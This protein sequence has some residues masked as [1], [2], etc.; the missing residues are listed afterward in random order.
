VSALAWSPDA[1][2]FAIGFSD[3][4]ITIWN[5][6][7][8]SAEY[9]Y[10]MHT[11]SLETIVWSPDGKLIAS[12]GLS[13]GLEETLLIINAVD[14]SVVSRYIGTSSN[15]SSFLSWSPDSTRIVT[16]YD[17][18]NGHS[19]PIL[20]VW[21][22]KTS[23]TLLTFGNA[24][25]QQVAWSPDGKTIA[26][27][28]NYNTLSLF[29]ASNGQPIRSFDTEGSSV[30]STS[31]LWSI[32]LAWSPDSQ[33][34]ALDTGAPLDIQVRNVKNNH[35]RSFPSTLNSPRV[36]MWLPDRPELS[37]TDAEGEQITFDVAGL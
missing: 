17:T 22:V 34:L 8:G 21:D 9:R 28:T 37:L 3:G 16:L 4:S 11:G 31:S 26:T 23:K 6:N 27:Y 24:N 19:Q 13:A 33:Y 10:H 15:G 30:P 2:R 12:A 25:V 20:Q 1:T 29:D 35:G 7:S 5:I 36:I 18:Q 14:S 32:Q